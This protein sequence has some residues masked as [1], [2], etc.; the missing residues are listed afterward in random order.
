MG[1]GRAPHEDPPRRMHRTENDPRVHERRSSSTQP[2][3]CLLDNPRRWAHWAAQ[4]SSKCVPIAP[5]DGQ[6]DYCTDWPLDCNV[7]ARPLC[8]RFAS[9]S[10]GSKIPRSTLQPCRDPPQSVR[11][12]EPAMT[13]GTK[14]KHIAVL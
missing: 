5:N 13:D 8:H 12:L 10:P 11:L 4:S 2:S 3:V 7:G 9:P 14:E 6:T 1:P